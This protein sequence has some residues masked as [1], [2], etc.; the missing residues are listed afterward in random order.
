MVVVLSYYYGGL[1][2][3]NQLSLDK[4]HHSIIADQQEFPIMEVDLIPTKGE[5]VMHVFSIN[6]SVVESIIKASSVGHAMKFRKDASTYLVSAPLTPPLSVDFK[7]RMLAT[8][9]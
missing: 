9:K 1:E 4:W 8:S 5:D 6:R 7:Y 2:R 3:K